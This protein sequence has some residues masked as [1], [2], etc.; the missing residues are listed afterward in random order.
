MD[1]LVN[2]ELD[3]LNG[4]QDIFKCGFCDKLF[5]AIT[6]LGDAGLF[7]IIIAIVLLFFK[8]TRKTGICMGIALLLGVF[9]GNLILKNLIARE[10]PYTYADAQVTAEGVKA[11][12]S[13]PHD[14]AFPSG[15]TLHAFT[16]ATMVFLHNRKAGA[17]L[18][19]LA[20]L[21]AFSRM[22]LF[23]HFPTDILAGLV[24]GIGVAVL[25]YRQSRKTVM[26]RN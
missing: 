5:T 22:Y 21:I 7:W 20:G 4:I 10:R 2:I 8:K 6:H 1:T 18:L 26:N 3:I 11:L 14:Y 12:I 15:H 23:V 9:F 17:W 16:A 13:L 24:L 25:V 19:V